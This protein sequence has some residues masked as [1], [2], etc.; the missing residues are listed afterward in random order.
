MQEPVSVMQ[1]VYDWLQLP[2]AEFDPQNLTVKPHESDSYYRFKY[3]HVTRT[4]IAAPQPHAVP[5][6]IQQQLQQKY[7]WFYQTFYPGLL[8]QPKEDSAP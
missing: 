6:R 7:A 4:A 8:P 5:S 2:K 3:P 1:G